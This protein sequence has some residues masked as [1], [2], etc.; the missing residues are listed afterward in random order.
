MA[1][2]S[3]L[4]PHGPWEAGGDTI[5][6]AADRRVAKVTG[7]TDIEAE[8]RA[9]LMAAAPELLAACRVA[10]AAYKLAGHDTLDNS[11]ALALRDAISKATDGM[12]DVLKG[13]G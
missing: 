8:E 7:D 4:L 13:G 6:D 9:W 1:T 5:Y 11:T 2:R 10:L 12:D 3:I